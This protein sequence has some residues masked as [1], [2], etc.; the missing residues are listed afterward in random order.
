M[1][2]LSGPSSLAGTSRPSPCA[3]RLASVPS[4]WASIPSMRSRMRGVQLSQ[5]EAQGVDQVVLLH[6]GL[7]V[8]E[9]GRLAEVIEELLAP[10]PLLGRVDPLRVADER[11]HVAPRLHRAAAAKRVRLVAGA[12]GVQPRPE[13][14][15]DASRARAGARPWSTSARSIRRGEAEAEW[16]KGHLGRVAP[17]G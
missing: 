1:L 4:T 13:I 10:S 16:T 11:A 5:L 3:T 7:A 17:V 8:P 15:R 12:A 6:V 14:A 2:W 9:Q